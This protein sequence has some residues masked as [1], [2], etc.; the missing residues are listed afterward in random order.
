MS[1]RRRRSRQR[2]LTSVFVLLLAMLVVFVIVERNVRPT[3]LAL[4]QARAKILA[5]EA[6]N[7][8]VSDELVATVKYQDL[9]AIQKDTR[10]RIVLMQPNTVEISRLASKVTT[11]VQTR[12]GALRSQQVAIPLGQVLGSSLLANLGPRIKVGLVPIGTVNVNLLN[13]FSAAGI[14]QTLHQLFL[15]V[16]AQVQIVIPLVF[17]VV[18]VKSVVPVAQTVIVGEVPQQYWQF[19]VPRS[20]SQ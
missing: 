10:G 9:I 14:N 17:S 1:W 13:Q 8:A 18:E 2:L 15:E 16:T 20:S 11:S 19:D 12:L 6:I 5:V 3:L 4:A 7:D